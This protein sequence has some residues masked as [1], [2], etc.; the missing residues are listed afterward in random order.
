[1]AASEEL[2]PLTGA[3]KLLGTFALALATFMNVLDTSI[4]NV[5]LSAIGGDLGVSTTQVTWVITSFGVANA[6][7]VPLT[8]W[9]S[10]R[11]GAVRLFTASIALFSI[12]SLLCGLAT[13]LQELIA[14]RVLQGA[15]AGPMIPLSQALL[16]SSFSKAKAG[17][18]L[19]IWA[20]TTLIAPVMG[21][22]LGG[23]I[24]DNISWPWIFYI[25]I[26]VG[27]FATVVTW[28]IYRNR[29]TAR[30]KLP[31]DGVGLGLL[32]LWVGALQVMLDKGQELDWFHSSTIIAL[33]AVAV[34][35]FCL[36][37]AW[38]LVENPYPVVDLRL[39]K[40][41][42][43]WTGT[44]ALAL[45]FGVFFG[46]V[47]IMPLWL[48]QYMGYTATEAGML[49][50]PVGILALLLSPF[51]GRWVGKFDLRLLAS[52]AFLI[53]AISLYMRTRYNT[54]ANFGFLVVPIIVQG[55]AMAFF[56]V[57]VVS[58]V[59]SGLSPERVPAASGLSNFARIVSGSF[60]TSI[61]TTL[62][63]NRAIVHHAQLTEYVSN[64]SMATRDYVQTLQ[65]GGLSFQQAGA[66][67]NRSID[68]ESHL[69]AANDLFWISSILFLLMIGVIWLA[70]PIKANLGPGAVGDAH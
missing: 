3:A 36:F 37:I 41:R 23:W 53:F 45:G 10:Q 20:M 30:R 35:V 29:E 26:P 42:N 46:N 55:A 51:V 34:I 59:L 25:N 1:M 19:A 27:V 24:T 40:R 18:A 49:T 5:S 48:Q 69:L 47:V 2:P 9:L 65:A 52:V 28:S 44:L 32:V 54:Q 8:G 17:T 50:A 70:R 62:W 15:V 43:F 66:A 14:F 61:A 11:F 56:F 31:I 64:S 63:D 16:L 38:E 22:L 12:A 6:I 39:F 4:A 33:A 21:P 7:A 57:P 67:I 68:V 13:S 58:L 60:G